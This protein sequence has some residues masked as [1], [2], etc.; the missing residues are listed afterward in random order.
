MHKGTALRA[1]TRAMFV[2]GIL[3]VAGC[4]NL[5]HT[6]AV[7]PMSAGGNDGGGSGGAGGSDGG[8]GM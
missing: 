6:T 2:A 1:L 4:A 5:P 3:A 7:F 8:M